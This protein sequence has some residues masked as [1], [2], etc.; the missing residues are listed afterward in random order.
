MTIER[1]LYKK[2]INENALYEDYNQKLQEIKTFTEKNLLPKLQEFSRNWNRSNKGLYGPSFKK[3]YVE[4]IDSAISIKGYT[5]TDTSSGELI[6]ASKSK[7]L[8]QVTSQILEKVKPIIMDFCKE[9]ESRF[10]INPIS[11]DDVE[12]TSD[13]IFIVL[14]GKGLYEYQTKKG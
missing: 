5:L 8:D 7:Y 11:E 9:L 12:I 1:D 2:F 3:A 13:E 14:G 6:N 4:M 10:P